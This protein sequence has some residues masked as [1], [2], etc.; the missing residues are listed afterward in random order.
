M[1][2]DLVQVLPIW[3]HKPPITTIFGNLTENI[4]KRRSFWIDTN[5]RWANRWVNPVYFDRIY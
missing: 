1:D 3:G 2:T 4:G 5:R